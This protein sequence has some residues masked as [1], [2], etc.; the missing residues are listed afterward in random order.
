MCVQHLM[1][2]HVVSV[3]VC[4]CVC[5]PAHVRAHACVCNIIVTKLGAIHNKSAKMKLIAD[6][7]TLIKLK[8]TFLKFL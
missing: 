4:V 7:E 2:V 5:V 6:L 8:C 3:C 1:V